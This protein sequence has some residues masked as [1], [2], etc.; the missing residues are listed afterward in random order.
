KLLKKTYQQLAENFDTDFGGFS[1]APKFPQPQNFHFLFDYYIYKNDKTSLSM[2]EKTLQQMF[3]G[4]IY[5]HIGF[6]FSRYATYLVW[7]VFSRYATDRALLIPHFEKMLYDNAQLLS[8]YTRAYSLT[9][10]PLYKQISEQIIVFI[11]R[12][13]RADDG[14]FYSAI[15]ADSEGEEG[16]Y[17]V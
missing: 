5:D 16:K 1:P 10:N 14:V 15:D 12:E 3:K 9:K 13:M 8:I 17:Y 4:G 6:G 7:F 11:S 2:A